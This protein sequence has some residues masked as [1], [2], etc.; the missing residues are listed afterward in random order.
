MATEYCDT[1][2]LLD[3]LSAA[4]VIDR[5]D[6]TPPHHLGEVIARASLKVDQHCLLLYEAGRLAQS[7]QIKQVAADIAAHLLCR[8]RGNPS[9]FREEYDEAMLYLRRVQLGVLQVHDI[10][11]RREV[12]PS[13]SNLRVRLDPFPRVVVERKRSAGPPVEDYRQ[14]YDA[15]EFFDYGMGI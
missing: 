6:D 13:V 14:N 15:L 12:V 9:V 8:R 7:E 4:G 3:R 2:D 11:A 1:D 10:A 5:S